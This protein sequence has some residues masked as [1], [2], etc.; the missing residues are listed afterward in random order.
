MKESVNEDRLKVEVCE[1]NER[2]SKKVRQRIMDGLVLE[3]NQSKLKTM[4]Q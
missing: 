3:I 2:R 4:Y 1:K